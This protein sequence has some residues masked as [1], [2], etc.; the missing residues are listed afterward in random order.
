MKKFFALVLTLALSV[1]VLAACN[2]ASK[3]ASTDKPADDKETKEAPK[4]NE[5]EKATDDKVASEDLYYKKIDGKNVTYYT[6][7][8]D[9]VFGSTAVLVAKD[10]KGLL[11]DTQ[12]SEDDAANI[13]DLIKAE[14]IDLET[15]Y[16]SYSDPDY[17]F[18]TAFIK[19]AFPNAKVL[20]TE[21]TI[22]RIKNSHEAKQA[23]WADVLKDKAPKKIIIPEATSGEITL[24][25]ETFTIVGEQKSSLF[26]ANDELLFGGILVSTDGHL[27]MADTKT[28]ESQQQ[29]LTDLTVLSE[30][31]PK[32]VVPGHF[33]IGNDFGENNIAFT[34]EYIEKFIEVEKDS[35]TSEEII[36]KMK[37]A[38]PDLDEGSLEMSAKVVTGEQEW[39]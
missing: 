10:G 3:E 11:V 23:V 35:K 6:M 37:E 26:N 9:A 33:A 1:V 16:V 12:F 31:H 19:E 39:E 27:F 29:W 25:D 18:G 36:T 24:G 4:A 38:Y 5:E 8:P 2:S 7:K 13:V 32:I 21:P 28:V 15:I 17:Y 14:N 22:E 34:K 30:L 20:A